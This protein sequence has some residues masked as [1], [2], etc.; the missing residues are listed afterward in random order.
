V[1]VRLDPNSPLVA[2]AAGTGCFSVLALLVVAVVFAKSSK[3][4]SLKVSLGC[5]TFVLAMGLYG[6]FKIQWDIWRGRHDLT[7][8]TSTRLMSLPR[9]HDGE[10]EV[11]IPLDRLVG[12][13]VE[14][15]Q[16]PNDSKKCY[17]TIAFNDGKGETVS[18]KLRPLPTNTLQQSL[19]NGSS[20]SLAEAATSRWISIRRGTNCYIVFPASGIQCIDLGKFATAEQYHSA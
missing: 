20:V 10:T 12:I 1:R 17:V 16:K 7:I 4:T 18:K 9:L 6:F 2:G 3:E 11:V 13:A 19:Q 14:A 15:G 5:L 8:E